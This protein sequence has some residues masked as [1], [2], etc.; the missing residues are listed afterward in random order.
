MTASLA[1]SRLGGLNPTA[2]L[3]AAAVVMAGLVVSASLVSAS[4]V[5]FFELAA[6]ALAGIAWRPVAVRA[7]PLPLAAAGVAIA[8]IVASDASPATIAAISLRLIA[9]ALPGVVVFASTEAV[10]LADSL[11][12]QLHVPARFAYGA[13]AGLR[14]LP[15]LGLEWDLIR[16]ARRARGI[17]ASGSPFRAAALF[18]STVY[19]LLVSAVRRATRLA[20]AM[21]SR[22]FALRQPRTTARRQQVHRADWALVALTAV[23]VAG[24]NVLAVVTGTWHAL[25]G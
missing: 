13:L 14:L 4:V 23:V 8:N 3:A 1:D 10:D 21:D 16:R 11:V 12:Q 18:A 9:I 24:A 7:W 15:L 22:G 5:L 25:L 17:D 6:L 19:A 20:L 2:K